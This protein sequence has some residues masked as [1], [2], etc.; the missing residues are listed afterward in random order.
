MAWS[1][2]E[3]PGDARCRP[4]SPGDAGNRPESPGAVR[5]RSSAAEESEPTEAAAS[6]LAVLDDTTAAAAGT[7]SAVYA[8]TKGTSSSAEPFCSIRLWEELH[9]SPTVGQRVRFLMQLLLFGSFY[10]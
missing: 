7:S 3:T 5:S 4:E 6:R 10:W 8:E 1:R 9:S 2:P